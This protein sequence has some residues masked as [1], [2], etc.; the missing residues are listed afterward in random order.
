MGSSLAE[1]QLR[2]DEVQQAFAE[3][4][5]EFSD[6]SLECLRKPYAETAAEAGL[7]FRRTGQRF[8][9]VTTLRVL[10]VLPDPEGTTSTMTAHGQR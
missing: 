8:I 1:L 2:V 10:G 3:V 4:G 9:E 5:P 7:M 6:T